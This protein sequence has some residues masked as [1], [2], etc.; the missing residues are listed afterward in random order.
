VKTPP[1]PAAAKTAKGKAARADAA[2]G[3]EKPRRLMRRRRR[4]LVALGVVALLAWGVQAIW[5]SAAPLVASRDRYLVPAAAITVNRTPDWIVADVCEQVVRESGLDRRLSI[6]DPNFP[7]AVQ[8][9]FALHPWVYSVDRVE[10]NFPPAVH[11]TVTYRRPMA[12]IEVPHGD[13][14]LLLPVDWH[15]IHLPAEDVPLIRLE[16]LPRIRGIVGRPPV[17]Q[18]WEDP[19]VDGAVELATLLADVWEPLHLREISPSARP[20]IQGARQFFVYELVTEGGT[21]IE[22]GA[23]PRAQAPGEAEF[24]VKLGRLKQCV[25]EYGP[26]NSVESSPG[27]IHVR[28]ELRVEPRIVKKPEAAGKPE[29]VVK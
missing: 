15:S 24:M 19:R 17:G 5:R 3:P 29:T 27:T 21:R 4:V 8:D 10:K 12:A 18:R 16:N 9:A 6:L 26:L 1:A 28:G 14:R 2:T 25:E 22:W 7:D 23:A 20:E 11:V 13:T